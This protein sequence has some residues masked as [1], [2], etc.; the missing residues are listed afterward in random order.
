MPEQS[1]PFRRLFV[2]AAPYTKAL[3]EIVIVNGTI[4]NK[5][6]NTFLY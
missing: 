3:I 5:N 4:G 6:Q 2:P 1:N